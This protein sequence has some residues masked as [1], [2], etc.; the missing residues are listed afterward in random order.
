MLLRVNGILAILLFR[1]RSGPRRFN[2]CQ[3]NGLGQSQSHGGVIREGGCR[4]H[5]LSAR[6]GRSHDVLGAHHT[7][8]GLG[9]VMVV[10]GRVSAV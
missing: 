2:E 3:P 9:E 10:M 7:A 1:A 8:V 5:A 6:F 4:K